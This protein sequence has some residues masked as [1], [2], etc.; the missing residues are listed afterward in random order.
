[1]KNFQEYLTESAKNYEYRI[2]IAGDLDDDA[3]TALE[4]ELAR[5]DVIKLS[6]PK[7]T[8]VL[9]SP[10]GFPELQNQEIH[11]MDVVLNYPATPQEITD[12][13]QRVGGNPN[14]IRIISKGFDDATNLASAEAEESPVLDK[15]LPNANA[16]QK[17]ASTAHADAEVVIKNSAEGAKFTVAGGKTA[18]AQ[19]TNDLPQGK[20]SPIGGTNKLPTPRSAA[21]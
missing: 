21:R 6:K 19:T 8:P 16:V 13:W 1:M 11:I 12:I 17:A 18:P 5:F 7:K 20:K 15:D 3:V 14:Y 4:K 2:K 9:K 10:A